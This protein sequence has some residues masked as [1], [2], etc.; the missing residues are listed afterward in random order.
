M[1]DDEQFISDGEGVREVAYE[2]REGGLAYHWTCGY[3]TLG[4][5]QRHCLHGTR[6]RA[7]QHRRE[8]WAAIKAEQHRLE[9]DGLGR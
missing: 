3:S 2:R 1:V 6:V 9:R 8:I 4:S 5:A 7:L